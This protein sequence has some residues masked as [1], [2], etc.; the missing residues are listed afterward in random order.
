MLEGFQYHTVLASALLCCPKVD[1][2]QEWTRCMHEYWQEY[3]AGKT[4]VPC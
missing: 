1:V 4:V 3:R 2:Y